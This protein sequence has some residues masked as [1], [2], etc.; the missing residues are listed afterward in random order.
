MELNLS[1]MRPLSLDVA[2]TL[3]VASPVIA[4]TADT[5]LSPTIYRTSPER[6]SLCIW[7]EEL[8]ARAA[9]RHGC[10]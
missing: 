8:H 6:H 10:Q 3:H 1:A 4:Y 5:Y 9:E 7:G 2:V